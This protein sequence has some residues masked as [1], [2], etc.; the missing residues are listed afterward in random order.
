[1]KTLASYGSLIT[2]SLRKLDVKSFFILRK[3]YSQAVLAKYSLYSSEVIHMRSTEVS[4]EISRPSRWSPWFFPPLPFFPKSDT[5]TL[6]QGVAL[7]WSIA[8]TYKLAAKFWTEPI[9]VA[10]QESA[11]VFARLRKEWFFDRAPR[12][13][14]CT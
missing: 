6:V 11:I 4:H 3:F 1:M 14:E 12:T 2:E 5:Y 13:R 9:R 7:V 10:S 8:P